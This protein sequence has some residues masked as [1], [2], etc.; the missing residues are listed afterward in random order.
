[1]GATKVTP[2]ALEQTRVAR[3]HASPLSSR[4]DHHRRRLTGCLLRGL[5]ALLFLA[6][7][8]GLLLS[9]AAVYEYY[10]IA[11][12]LPSVADLRQKSSQFETTR[13]YDR[14]GDLLYEILDP[15]AGKRTYVPLSEI[16]P[17]LIAMTLAA[18]DKDFYS[19]GGFDPLAIVRAFWENLISGETVSGASTITQQLAR[20][21]LLTPEERSQETYLRKVREAILATE[22]EQSYSKDEILELYL[23][24]IYYGNLSY[25]VE[26]AAETY[27][28]TTA[29]QLTLGQ[30]AFLAGLPSAPSYYDIYTNPQATLSRQQV[31]VGLAFKLSEERNCIAVSNSSS[32]VCM[33][34]ADAAQAVQEIAAY[35]FTPPSSTLVYPHW[36]QYIRTELESMYDPQTIYRSGFS[37][38]TTLDPTLE[39][40]AQEIVTYQISK[41]S[42]QHVTGGALVAIQPSTGEILAMVGSPDFYNTAAAGQINMAVSPT[43]QPGSSIKLLTYLAAFEKG[44]TPATLI[45]DVP[46]KF[47]PSGLP[48]DTRPPYIPTNFDNTYHGP[49]TVR[50]ALANSYNIPAVKALQFVGVY[51]DPSNPQTGGL[52]NMAERLGITSLTSPDYGLALTLGG[53]DVSL[54]QLTGAYAVVAN[55]GVRVPPVSILKIVDYQGNVVYQ[56]QPPAGEQ[57]L[58][59]E[60]TYLMDSILSDTVARVPT[61]GANSI[62][63]LSFQAAAKTGTSNDERDNWTLG[64]TPDLTVGVWVGN[65]DYTPMVN[66]TGVTGAGPIWAQFMSLAV[67]Y[68]THNNPTPFARPSGVIQLTI[69]SL[70]GTLPSEWCPAERTEVFAAGQPPLPASDDLWKQISI[71]TWTGLL[72]SAACPDF[73]KTEMVINTQDSSA[74]QWI[75]GTE[76][77]Q[78]WARV[79]GF[80]NILFPPARACAASDP[81]PDLQFSNLTDGETITTDSLNITVVASATSGFQSFTLEYG[82]GSNPSQW[83]QLVNSTSPVTTPTTVSAWDLTGLPYQQIT[84]RLH[85]QGSG[86]AYAERMVHLN[87]SLPTATPTQTVTATPTAPPT[88]TQ[89]PTSIPSSTSS[90]SATSVTSAT[91]SP[92]PTVLPSPTPTPPL[93][94]ATPAPTAS[95]TS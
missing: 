38:Y 27:F 77:G 89:M 40:A 24:E 32:P 49:V 1:M 33:S 83:Y 34:A 47:T 92:F 21:L 45:W 54:L 95:P 23:N 63:D 75:S 67:P 6:V 58:A 61:Y 51:G 29:S 65:P 3:S 42:A 50:T 82:V 90:P 13:I 41:L 15:N 36:V 93:P 43:R 57:V 55:G 68:L 80:T 26:A 84:L 4:K 73:T 10:A 74:Q 64:Y 59:P 86:S 18:E 91:P 56:Y 60:H 53:G 70:S 72:S 39:D 8:L 12:T 85:M 44:W 87:L 78:K 7:A 16:S 52:I 28:N 31:V 62:L 46:T 66:T 2:V 19:H 14:S 35:N 17:N 20:A 37:V 9:A 5:I 81:R 22:I 25:G 71:D 11:A 94:S 69:C 30:A 79:N 76:Q 48:N 88:A